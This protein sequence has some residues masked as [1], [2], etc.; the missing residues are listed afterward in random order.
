MQYKNLVIYRD[1]IKCL[2]ALY[3]KEATDRLFWMVLFRVSYNIAPQYLSDLLLTDTFFLGT[4]SLFDC[5]DIVSRDEASDKLLN[6]S[7][8]YWGLKALRSL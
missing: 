6:M 3:L 7:N 4:Y 5:L 8:M 2:T 1:Y